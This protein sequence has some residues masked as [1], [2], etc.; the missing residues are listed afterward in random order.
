MQ[1]VKHQLHATQHKT[2]RQD[3]AHTHNTVHKNERMLI[4]CTHNR[5]QNTRSM[6]VR[7]P[8]QNR[9]P[10]RQK[11]WDPN[12]TPHTENDRDR[13]ARSSSMLKAACS[14]KTGQNTGVSG[15]CH[16]TKRKL[17]RSDR[18]LTSAALLGHSLRL[19]NTHKL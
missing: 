17:D 14:H 1:Q 15:L 6:N 13:R 16:Q 7:I 4:L 9:N 11:C 12:T 18:T 2:H 10:T 3:S 8:T 5:R 19:R